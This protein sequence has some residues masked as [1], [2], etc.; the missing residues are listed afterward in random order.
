MALTNTECSVLA[1]LLFPDVKE[2]REDLEKRFPERDLGEGACVTRIAPSPTGFVHFGNLFPALTSERLAH[3]SGGVFYLRIEDTDALREVE[4]AV[5]II[6][7]SFKY[8]GL[9]FDEGATIDGDFGSYGPYRQSQRAPIYHV[10]AKELVEKGLAYPCFC[11]KEELEAIREQQE[12]QK[13]LPGYYGEWAKFRDA[14][15][16]EVKARVEAG[17]KWVLRLRSPGKP[18]GRIRVDDVIKGKLE[19]DENYDDKVLLKSD[20]IPTYHF[21][22]AVD[23]HLM[24]TTHVVRGEEWLSSLPFHVQLFELLGFRMPRYVHIAQLMKL[25]GVSKR[26]LSKRHDPEAALSFYEAKGYPA[27]SVREYV[28][29]LLNSNFEEWRA[30]NPGADIDGF[31]FTTEKMSSSGSLFDLKK[32]EDVSKNTVAAFDADKVLSLV[33]DWSKTHDEE[34]FALLGRDRE[35]SR[36]IFAIGRGGEKPRKDL[37]SWDEVREYAGFFFDELFSLRDPFPENVSPDDAK[38]ILSGFIS[39]YDPSDDQTAWFSKITDLSVANGF[40]AKI[41]EY[42]KD[43]SAYKGHVGDV[44]MVLRVAGTGKRNSPDMYEVMRLLGRDKVAGRVKAALEV[45]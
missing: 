3:Q 20:G 22:H 7:N 11:S 31:K 25:D 14:P 43:P 28:M 8:Y 16:D 9:N 34:L 2:T 38:A 32:L 1:G 44:S 5:E 18:G 23:D 10:F 40:A 6:I 19:L 26:K 29:T 35:F 36:G 15:L 37:A 13:L 42:K 33:L 17:E 12:K 41:K 27:D 45:L 21:A 30:Q 39:G 24:R 4:G